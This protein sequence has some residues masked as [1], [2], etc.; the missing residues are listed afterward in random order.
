MYQQFRCHDLDAVGKH[1]CEQFFI[2]FSK[3]IRPL[4]S[5]N[6]FEFFCELLKSLNASACQNVP[7]FFVFN[8]DFSAFHG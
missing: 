4:Q 2:F 1:F 5:A 8:H 7:A 6:V 3:R